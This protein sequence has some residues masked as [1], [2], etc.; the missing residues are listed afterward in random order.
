MDTTHRRALLRLLLLYYY[1]Y[2]LLYYYY[3][4]YYSKWLLEILDGN[5]V[6][7]LSTCLF[8]FLSLKTHWDEKKRKIAPQKDV[9]A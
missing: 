6:V 5:V 2:I 9:H 3:Y 4:Y 7:I 1:Y 8:V